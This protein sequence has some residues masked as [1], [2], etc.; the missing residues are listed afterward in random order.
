M[1]S[2]VAVVSVHLLMAGCLAPSAQ[3][4]REVVEPSPQGPSKRIMRRDSRTPREETRKPASKNV[5]KIDKEPSAALAT[6]ENDVPSI[7]V[8]FWDADVK[9]VLMLLARQAG[10]NVVMPAD[11]QGRITLSLRDVPWRAAFEA[12]AKTAGY[13]VVHEETDPRR[14]FRVVRAEDFRAQRET[15]HWALSYLRPRDPYAAIITNV[16]NLCQ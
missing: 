10:A 12:V 7:T 15:R 11:V 1:R 5:T 13:V 6:T 4:P 14:T 2:S 9:V 16:E 8:E 3:Q